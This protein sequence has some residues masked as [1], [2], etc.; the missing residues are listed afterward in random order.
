MFATTIAAA[1]GGLVAD[2]LGLPLGFLIG[3]MFAVAALSLMNLPVAVIPNGRQAAQGLIGI[4]AGLRMTPEVAERLVGLL[5]V[6]IGAALSVILCACL[7]SV[8]IAKLTRLDADTAFFSSLPGGIAEMAVLSERYGGNPGL[9]SIGQF[10]RILLVTLAVPQIV[11]ALKNSDL[12]VAAPVTAAVPVQWLPLVGICL[13]ALPLALG[14]SRLKVPNAWLLSGIIAGAVLAITEWQ[15]TSVPV[16]GLEIAQ[17]VVGMSLGAR[18]TRAVFRDGYR[19]LPANVIG[20]LTLIGFA[21]LAATLIGTVFHIDIVS[22]VLALA[23]GGIAEMSLVS[24]QVG[25]DTVLVVAFHLVRVIMVLT[26]AVLLKRIF[27]GRL[28]AS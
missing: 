12:T 18:C 10:L 26:L 6:M 14:L 13:V 16:T 5:P 20:T 27:T 7:I 28:S 15:R 22:L 21:T 25:G 24:A 11:I 2:A 19:T 17:I 9:V 3:A 8:A 4:G 23:P 1:I